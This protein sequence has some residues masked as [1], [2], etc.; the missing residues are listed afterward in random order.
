MELVQTSSPAAWLAP[1]APDTDVPNPIDRLRG[2]CRRLELL[3]ARATDGRPRAFH[4]SVALVHDICEALEDA[5]AAG[6]AREQLRAASDTARRIFGASSFIRRLQEWPRGYPGDF[7]TIEQLWRGENREPAGS[8]AHVFE[9][10]ALTATIAQQHR[11]KVA[12]QAAA[13]RSAMAGDRACRLLSIGCGSCPDLRTAVDRVTPG[14]TFVLCDSDADALVQSRRFLAPIAGQ[15]QFVHGMVP[16][17]LRRIRDSGPFDLIVAGGLFD[18]LSD[19]MIVHTLSTAWRTLLAPGGR[20]LFTNIGRGNPFRVWL[21]Y[22]ADWRLIERSEAD[23]IALCAAA[24]IT[25]TPALERDATGLS[26]IA[27]VRKNP[28]A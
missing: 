5:E 17:V 18:Y 24:G 22:V 3:A 26:I 20:L 27:D 13:I 8:L 23:V 16:R 25:A 4:R 2:A 14:S 7:E 12:F 19:R 10:Y 1:A 21:E 15:C 11:N 9:S 28:D 6:Y